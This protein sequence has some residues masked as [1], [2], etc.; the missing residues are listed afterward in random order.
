MTPRE[1]ARRPLLYNNIDGV[2]ELGL[3]LLFSGCAMIWLFVPHLSMIYFAILIAIIHYGSKAIKERI[4]YPRTG[5]VEYR[6]SQTV[7]IPAI[8][9]AVVSPLLLAA[10][11]VAHRLHWKITTPAALYGL[12]FAAGYAWR[13]ALTVRWK[14][15]IAAL[16]AGG[17]LTIAFLPADLITWAAGGSRPG[18][19]LFIFLFCGTLL[20]I[21][22]GITFWFYLRHTHPPVLEAA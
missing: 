16:M 10:F 19:L 20:L 9:G 8:L 14:W 5:F 15:A 17:S 6:R 1:I 18:P 21:S 2:G 12:I 22:G 11:V 13:L 3:G 7:W 4:T